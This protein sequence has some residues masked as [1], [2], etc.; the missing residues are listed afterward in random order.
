VT[1]VESAGGYDPLGVAVLA[2]LAAASLASIVHLAV[3][4]REPEYRRTG[5]VVLLFVIA[6][7]FFPLAPLFWLSAYSTYV[8]PR[9]LERRHADRPVARAAARPSRPAA[10]PIDTTALSPLGRLA[11]TRRAVRASVAGGGIGLAMFPFVPL[12]DDANSLTVAS[13]VLILVGCVGLSALVVFTQ[14]T[15]DRRLQLVWKDFATVNGFE[16]RAVVPV[17]A[18]GGVLGEAFPDARLEDQ[19]HGRLANGRG[20]ERGTFRTD[21]SAL[22][23]R[24][25]VTEGLQVVALDVGGNHPHVVVRNRADRGRGGAPSMLVL[26]PARYR[27]QLEDGDATVVDVYARQPLDS[28][29]TQRLRLVL[30]AMGAH[31]W[32]GDIELAGDRVHLYADGI[33][34][35]RAWFDRLFSLADEVSRAISS[36]ASTAGPVERVVGITRRGRRALLSGLGVSALTVALFAAMVDARPA[37]TAALA[38]AGLVAGWIVAVAVARWVGASRARRA[39]HR[40]AH[41]GP[42]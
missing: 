8:R 18:S 23:G 15:W 21:L 34:H 6:I 32:Y 20:F 35:P 31:S 13:L 36:G 12:G 41:R 5:P 1:A 14:M 30:A 3:L 29:T 38:V 19:V 39:L 9:S 10:A 2:L 42:A 4:L 24:L 11:A 17:Q 26:P 22:G 16:H 28:T 25:N 27:Q 33:V 7:V 40:A 37:Y